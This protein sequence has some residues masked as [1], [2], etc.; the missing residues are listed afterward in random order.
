[1]SPEWKSRRTLGQALREGAAVLKV[2]SSPMLDARVLL[3]FATGI[4][5]ADLIARSDASLMDLHAST[6]DALIAR[7][8]RGEPIAYIT[9]E[10]E[11]WSLP[12]RVSP[13]VLI[14]RDDSECL[15]E[16]VLMRRARDEDLTMLDLGT[17]SGCL[18]GALLTEFPNS[19]GVGIDHSESAAKLARANAAALGLTGRAAFTSGDWLAPIGGAFDIIIANPPY[20]PDGERSELPLDVAEFEPSGALFAGADGLDDYRSILGGLR[21]SQGLLRPDGLLV[22][23]AGEQQISRLGQMVKEAFPAADAAVINDLK[24]RRRGVAADFRMGEKR[25]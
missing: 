24:G 13:D 7:R 14:P 9:G 23:E 19:F 16:S 8:A 22:F 4:D 15:I 6:F 10:K 25:D 21:A 3:K 12:F 20:I 18:L 2:S 1:M 11:F 17:G 5:D